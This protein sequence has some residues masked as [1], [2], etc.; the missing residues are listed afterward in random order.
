MD[1]IIYTKKHCD[2][3][4]AMKSFLNKYEIPYMEKD[5][6]DPDV[7]S[8]LVGNDFVKDNFCDE[9]ECIVITPVINVDGKW[10]YKEF[11]GINGFAEYRA[12]KFFNIT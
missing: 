7:G 1:V 8:E 6:M 4:E 2:R 11:F 5:I 3:C 9:N 12:K 10:L